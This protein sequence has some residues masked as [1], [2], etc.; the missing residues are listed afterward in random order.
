[1]D[2][3]QPPCSFSKHHGRIQ[4]THWG[5]H[6][7]RSTYAQT[8]SAIYITNWECVCVC[9]ELLAQAF[10]ISNQNGS[11]NPGAF[12]RQQNKGY[13]T[14]AC[15]ELV[16]LK[17]KHCGWSAEIIYDRGTCLCL[18]LEQSDLIQSASKESTP[19]HQH[20]FI[21]KGK[22]P[23]YFRLLLKRNQISFHGSTGDDRR[24]KLSLAESHHVLGKGEERTVWSTV[25][26]Q[27]LNKTG[28]CSA[29][30]LTPPHLRKPQQYNDYA[31][32]HKEEV[33]NLCSLIQ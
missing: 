32:F 24:A 8:V 16:P 33:D 30:L 26:G 9:A 22:Q 15:L 18:C 25:Q 7:R 21:L 17:D 3:C 14:S 6:H 11:E 13:S 28:E 12:C 4:D 20:L 10:Y 23:S 31:H 1:M 27:G 5:K 2:K 29:A 19:R